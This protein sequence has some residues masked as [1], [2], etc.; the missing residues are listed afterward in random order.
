[1]QLSILQYV[2]GPEVRTM[3][4]ACCRLTHEG[5]EEF[6][7]FLIGWNFW[8]GCPDHRKRR[9]LLLNSIIYLLNS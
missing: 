3:R 9:E 4:A 5:W 8:S 1:M 6:S 7:F 2:N